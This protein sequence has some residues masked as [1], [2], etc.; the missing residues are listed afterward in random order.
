M[1]VLKKEKEIKSELIEP[2]IVVVET[3]QEYIN[4]LEATKR[5]QENELNLL[6][7]EMNDKLGSHSLEIDRLR[8]LLDEKEE[9]IERLRNENEELKARIGDG[10]KEQKNESF[11]HQFAMNCNRI[12]NETENQNKVVC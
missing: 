12:E 9:L 3:Q 1:N 2:S 11:G 10:D 6:R 5:R 7:R 8:L 4:E